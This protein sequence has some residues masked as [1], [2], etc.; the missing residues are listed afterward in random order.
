MPGA[1]SKGE[2]RGF[3]YGVIKKKNV[4]KIVVFV[5]ELNIPPPPPPELYILKLWMLWYVSCFKN[6][7]K[8]VIWKKMVLFQLLKEYL[9]VKIVKSVYKDIKKESLIELYRLDRHLT[10]PLLAWSPTSVLPCRPSC[11]GPLW[12]PSCDDVV[13]CH[14]SFYY[15]G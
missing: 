11:G 10:T 7:Y 15:I 14:L 2:W 1:G 6:S 13:R 3:L 5:V 8:N 4:L 9:L 12:W